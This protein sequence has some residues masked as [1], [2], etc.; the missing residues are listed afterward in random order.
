MRIIR[1]LIPYS[2]LVSV[3]SG[4]L[5]ITAPPPQSVIATQAMQGPVGGRKPQPVEPCLIGTRNCLSADLP[6]PGPCLASTV[7]CATEGMGVVEAVR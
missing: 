5:T 2:A 6:P 4:C 1:V 7:R 3:L